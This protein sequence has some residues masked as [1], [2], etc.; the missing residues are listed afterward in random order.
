VKQQRAC[1]EQW[2]R[3]FASFEVANFTPESKDTI[4]ATAENMGASEGPLP[5]ALLL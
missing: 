3:A 4:L 5:S 1:S 2:S